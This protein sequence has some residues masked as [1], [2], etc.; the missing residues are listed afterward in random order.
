MAETKGKKALSLCILRVLEKHATKEQ[1]LTTRA[2]IS[3]LEADYGMIAERKSVGRNL[4]LLSEMGFELSTYQ[5]NGK[6][7]YLHSSQKGNE[8][9]ACSNAVML[10]ALLRAPVSSNAQAMMDG[11]QDSQVPIHRVPSVKK[12]L[13]ENVTITL[14]A[15]KVAIR[16][17]VQISF[18]YNNLRPDGSL[19]PQR[20][21]PYV[22]SPYALAFADEHYY[23]IVSISG[24]GRPLCY[25]CDLMSELKTVDLPVRPVNELQGCE[26][27]LDVERFISKSLYQ[28]NEADTHV[29]LCA[30]H[31]I[32]SLLDDF[33]ATVTMEEEGD[34]V[35]ACIVAPWTRVHEFLLKNLKHTILLA[36]QNRRVQLKE[37]LQSAIS[38]YPNT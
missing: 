35:R 1:P 29:L 20:Q 6:G 4:L 38:C 22:A 16:E 13:Q 18:L 21:T 37:E 2:I 15:L 17:G 23:V 30:R 34:T 7:Y 31:L 11:L 32:G 9:V 14:E 25:R 24:Y 19:Q 10:D 33:A 3:L 8:E 12:E 36:P 27:G 26:N 5:D 28:A